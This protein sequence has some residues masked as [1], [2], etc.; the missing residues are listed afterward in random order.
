MH[1]TERIRA[2]VIERLRE[3]IAGAGGNE[4]FAVGVMDDAGY[5]DEITVAAR[6]NER[7]VPVVSSYVDRGDVVIHNHPTG[8]LTPSSAD[9]DVAGA[10]AE[11]GVGFFIID[12]DVENLYVVIEPV[13]RAQT[14]PLDLDEME[15]ILLPGG[16]LSKTMSTY[17]HRSQQ[18]EMMLA[19]ARG[20][21]ENEIVVVEAGTGVGKSLAYLIPA[22]LWAKNNEERVVISTGTIN[23]QQ[24]LIDKDIPLVKKITGADIGAALVKGRGNYLCPRRLDELI[25]EEGLFAASDDEL[26]AMREW[27]KTTKTGERS[28]LPFFPTGETWNRVRSETDGCHALRCANRGDCYVLKA[29]R[30]AASAQILVTNHHLLFSDLAIRLSSVGRDAT[31]V[32]PPF[33][34]IIIDEAHNIEKNA[35]S[36]FSVRFDKTSVARA[37]AA[38][39]RERRGRITGALNRIEKL[40]VKDMSEKLKGL[41]DILRDASR[42]SEDFNASVCGYMTERTL[43]IHGEQGVSFVETT[44]DLVV[45]LKQTL[46]RAVERLQSAI[47]SIPDEYT[48]EDSVL[49]VKIAVERLTQ[50]ASVLDDLLHFSEFPD[51]VFWTEK[52]RTAGEDT[53]ATIHSTPIDIRET[54]REAVFDAYDTVVC[55]SATLSVNKRFDFFANRS[56][57]TGLRERE[58]QFELHES[59]FPFRE[60]VL[61]AVT[62]DAPEPHEDTYQGFVERIVGDVLE[63]SEGSGLVLFT[64]YT[65]LEKTY[66]AVE[67]RLAKL[68]VSVLRQ[69]TADRTKLLSVFS[70]DTGSVLFATSSFWEG[71]DAP[72]KALEIVIICRLPFSVPNDPVLEARLES[73]ERSGGNAFYEL[74]LPQAVMRFKQGFG[75]LMRR[76]SDRGSV[77]VLDPRIVRRRYGNSFIDSLPGPATA[78]TDADHVL[79]EIERFLYPP[80]ANI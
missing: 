74:S 10:F 61:L 39:Y 18:I 62:T 38:L 1:P 28:D 51:R 9:L 19:V 13:H 20:F 6:G 8:I 22:F 7:A 30:N 53:I 66:A 5:I 72:G 41:I 65:M 77:V 76:T 79:E 32:L 17:E 55:T 78:F 70:T 2:A 63:L 44:I 42:M 54:M 3:E 59:P 58:V 25:D 46:V 50:L 14:T 34:R 43:R 35:T 37:I 80:T 64:S 73:I 15:S 11:S 68:G 71:V 16:P 27:A 75:R 48:D 12:S 36:F 47:S 69:G 45:D 57:L 23:L 21:N 33:H 4:V 40:F 52:R 26:M 29:R 24:Q 31:A 67:P 56:G 49:D 60:R